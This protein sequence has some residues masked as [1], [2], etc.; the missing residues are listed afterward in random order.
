[1]RTINLLIATF[2]MTNYC[3]AQLKVLTNGNVGIGTLTPS[4][5]LHVIGGNFMV[6][7]G[8]DLILKDDANDPGDLIFRN[9]A[10]TEYG[11]VW[12]QFDFMRFRANS[13]RSGDLN[14]KNS[15][16]YVSVGFIDPAYRLDVNGGTIRCTSLIQTSDR[17]L[18]TGIT[19]ISGASVLLS[20]ME[21]VKYLLRNS[22]ERLSRNDSTMMIRTADNDGHQS[23]GFIAQDIQKIL[24]EIVSEDH[25]GYLSID[26]IAIIP[27]LVNAFNEQREII[28]SLK[29]EISEL[30]DRELYRN[31]PLISSSQEQK[32]SKPTLEIL[33]D[34]PQLYQ[35][36]PNPFNQDTE[37]KY[38]VPSSSI[39]MNLFIFDLQGS[40][41][42][43][44]PIRSTGEGSYTLNGGELRPGLYVYSLMIDGREVASK[45]MILTN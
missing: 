43:S 18:K 33:D 6:Y 42:K 11:R 36:T 23:F 21:G 31:N 41:I 25:N 37:I 34:L 17:R 14:I 13:S 20:K 22:G 15:N 24:P 38:Y 26:Y 16:G 3:I 8:P 44:I 40:L 19:G 1:M 35:N 29:Q 7:G 28:E 32:S 12:A 5:R 27:F 30:K 9:S 4:E 39:N 2:F 45:R 10:N